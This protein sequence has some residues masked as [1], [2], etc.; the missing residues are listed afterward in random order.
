MTENKLEFIINKDS[1]N[2][3]VELDGMSVEAA[4]AFS[5]LLNSMIKIVRLNADN[6]GLKIQIKSGS[7]VLI[8]EGTEAQIEEIQE[9][10]NEI[11]SFKSANKQLVSEWRNIQKLFQANGLD[12]EA[13]IY[14]K[15]SKTS[16]L[17]S[18]K[19]RKALRSKPVSKPFTPT[20]RFMSGKLI[21]VGGNNPNLHLE[22]EP[23]A[24]VKIINCTEERAKKANRFLYERAFIS[25]WVK[26]GAEDERLELCDSYYNESDFNMLNTFITDFLST[27]NEI[28][29]LKM[30]HYKCRDFLDVQDYGGFRRFIRLFNHESTDVNILKT[31][32]IITQ[33][34]KEHEN[35]KDMRKDIKDLFD[36]KMKEYKRAKSKNK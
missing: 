8:A 27:S 24:R 15:D 11:I 22:D 13:H 5:V 17:T 33:S 2:N 4:A 26:I 20:I 21:A 35:L 3:K 34:F 25:C 18:L 7:A 9:N 30:L 12:Y 32:L 23:G 28:N 36:K 6:E 16:I 10:F 29:Q 31:I 14:T 1:A 19:A